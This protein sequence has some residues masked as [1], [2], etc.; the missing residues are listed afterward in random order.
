MKIRK[1]V[2]A[3][4]MVG[5]GLLLPAATSAASVS[6]SSAVTSKT[7]SSA[8]R[9]A[10]LSGSS[11]SSDSSTKNFS[12]TRGWRS[13]I[14]CHRVTV[15]GK[16]S[17]S[18]SSYISS[19][20]H[21]VTKYYSPKV[22]QPR[23]RVW[24]YKYCYSTVQRL[25]KLSV[26]QSYSSYQCSLNPSLSASV[27]FALGLSIT[28]SCGQTRVAYDNADYNVAGSYYV[29]NNSGTKATFPSYNTALSTGPCF[30]PQVTLRVYRGSRSDNVMMNMQRVCLP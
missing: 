2:A 11:R 1:T 4:V 29:M 17:Y 14:G 5:V 9:P 13:A 27:P 30:Q 16:I 3:L 7:G 10:D 12:V 23:V 19:A 18:T 24:N 8:P 26:T 6:S 21:R 15:D 28:P 25:S 20:G 22:V